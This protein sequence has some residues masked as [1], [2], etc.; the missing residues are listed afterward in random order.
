MQKE[1]VAG[2]RCC[3]CSSW[4]VVVAAADVVRCVCRAPCVVESMIAVVDVPNAASFDARTVSRWDLLA[5]DN[6]A[7]AVVACCCRCCCVSCYWQIVRRCS[8]GALRS[9]WR[10]A[11]L[12][13][14]PSRTPRPS[15]A[16]AFL[17]V[18]V[19]AAAVVVVG[20]VEVLS[21]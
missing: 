21:F 5:A 8:A 9:M 20:V 10:R 13:F 11:C 17:F 18:A 14:D 19:V 12:T 16:V 7:A 15:A 6:A 2:S 4:L 3:F 1:F